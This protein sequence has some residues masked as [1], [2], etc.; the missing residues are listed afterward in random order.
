MST[1]RTLR[2]LLLLAIFGALPA[3]LGSQPADLA[4]PEQDLSLQEYI[5]TL[6]RYSAVLSDS[7]PDA[8]AHTEMSP[9]AVHDLRV[10]LPK[11]WIVHAGEQRYRVETEWLAAALSSREDH[12]FAGGD[13]VHRAKQ[14]LADLRE[15][16]EA[17]AAVAPGRD[18][19]QSR[20]RL[21]RILSAREF[22]GAHGPSWLDILKARIYAWIFRQLLKIWGR[23]GRSPAIGT[24]IAWTV[25][26]LAALLLAFWAVRA[27]IRA[28]SRS[29]MD[30]HGASASGWGWRDWLEAA[31]GA[32]NRG[33]YRAAIHAAYWAAIA[34][35]EETH[36]LPEDR[37]RTPRESLRLLKPDSAAY[38]PLAQM[39]KRFELVWYGHR[40]ATPADWNDAIQQLETLGCLRSSTPATAGS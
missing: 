40:A 36:F 14:R 24:T 6:D 29:E 28:G 39:T 38:T 15:A 18:L 30:L 22:Q 9:A 37:S 17:T 33:D 20:A 7:G 27:T 5:S 10:A 31:R 13:L 23:V 8:G 32:A 21:D 12:R 3:R 4:A 26:V 35:L 19:Q 11:A 25:V 16:A 34:R 1:A 2:L